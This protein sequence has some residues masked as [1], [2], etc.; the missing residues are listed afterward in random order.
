MADGGAVTTDR[1]RN[2][3][4]QVS[5]PW[6]ERMGGPSCCSTES[7]CDSQYLCPRWVTVSGV[8]RKQVDSTGLQPTQPHSNAL[9]C[10]R[11]SSSRPRTLPHGDTRTQLVI[12][13]STS[14]RTKARDSH[15]GEAPTPHKQGWKRRVKWTDGGR[16]LTGRG[17]R[18]CT[19]RTTPVSSAAAP[20]MPCT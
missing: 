4:S 17:C 7:S 9:A 13:P 14:P 1:A 16:G 15:L 8:A 18:V 5:S 10:I 20:L 19:Q 2:V 12:N 3:S 11:Y 6:T